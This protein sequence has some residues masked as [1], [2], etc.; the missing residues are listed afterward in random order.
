MKSGYGQISVGLRPQYV[1]RISYEL[2]SGPVES[3]LQ[4]LHRC[5][6]RCCVNPEHLFVGTL[7]DNMDDMTSKLRQAHG[8]K[9]FHAKLK[10][11]DVHAIR[12]STELQADL[13]ERYGVTQ[14]QISVIKAE[15]V[16]RY[17]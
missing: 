6:N 15:K 5:D 12:A 14:G 13:A 16:W 17:V 4:V 10:T 7:Q 1:H 11:E 8:P 2:A 3:G 9:C